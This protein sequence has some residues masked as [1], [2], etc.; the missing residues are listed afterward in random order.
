VPAVPA[1]IPTWE[2]LRAVQHYAVVPD[3]L[4]EIV[5]WKLG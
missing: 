1:A 5:A 2:R 3:V 4:T